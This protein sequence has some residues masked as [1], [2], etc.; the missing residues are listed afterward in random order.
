MQITS[1]KLALSG[2]LKPV[3]RLGL[4]LSDFEQALD[5]ERKK[6]F[7]QQRAASASSSASTSLSSRQPPRSG[8][9]I[10][11]TEE[12]HQA[13]LREDRLLPPRFA[14]RLGAFFSRIQTFA[15]VGD[16]LIGGSQNLIA[17]GVWGALRFCLLG[18]VTFSGYLEKLSALFMRLGTSWS[19][20]ERFAELFPQSEVLQQ[21]LCE[22]LIVVVVLCRK[23]V[24][25]TK[26]NSAS[27]F[28]ATL[29]SSFEDEFSPIQ[30]KMDQWGSIIERQ[31][32]SLAMSLNIKQGDRS[33]DLLSG[34]STRFLTATRQTRAEALSIQIIQ[35]LSAGQDQYQRT[36]RRQKAKGACTWIF[37]HESYKHWSSLSGSSA[38]LI[39]EGKLGSGKTVAMANLVAH[40][41]ANPVRPT[42][43]VFCAFKEPDSQTAINMLRSIAYQIIDNVKPDWTHWRRLKRAWNSIV[44]SLLSPDD[45]IDFLLQLMPQDKQY[46][47][48]IDG[49]ESCPKDESS[50]VFRCLER[51]MHERTVFL[52]YSARTKSRFQELQTRLPPQVLSI[53]LDEA[54][55]HEEIE[56]FIRQEI[57]RRNSNGDLNPEIVSLAVKQLVAGSQGMY[58]WVSLQLDSI[59]PRDSATV[60]TNERVFD[61]LMS[62]PQNLPEAFERA[63]ESITDSSYGVRILKLVT[64]AETPLTV[65]ELRVALTITPGLPVWNAERVPLDGRRLLT[66]CGGDLIEVDEE[67]DRVRVIHYSVVRHLQTQTTNPETQA[68]HCSHEQSQNYMGS[69]CVTY[70]NLPLFDSRL[71]ITSNIEGNDVVEKIKSSVQDD[72]TRLV[73]LIKYIKSPKQ[74][75]EDPRE[76]DLGRLVLEAQALRTSWASAVVAV[77]CFQD[78]AVKHWLTHTQTL[79]DGGEGLEGCWNLWRRLI[80][81]EVQRIASPFPDPRDSKFEAMSWAAVHRHGALF[82]FLLTDLSVPERPELSYGE[83]MT[84]FR[85]L[86]GNPTTCIH[87]KWLGNILAQL[88]HSIVVYREHNLRISDYQ[89][90]ALIFKELHS[91]GADPTIVHHITRQSPMEIILKCLVAAQEDSFYMKRDMDHDRIEVSELLEMQKEAISLFQMPSVGASLSED[92][93]PAMFVR[94]IEQDMLL[95]AEKFVDWGANCRVDAQQDSPLGAAVCH[96]HRDLVCRMVERSGRSAVDHNNSWYR[97]KP[98]LELALDRQDQDM[99]TVLCKI[100]GILSGKTSTGTTFLDMTVKMM[101]LGWPFLLLDQIPPD[102]SVSA[103][104]SPADCMEALKIAV[105]SNRTRLTLKLMSLC[106]SI[107]KTTLAMLSDVA[108][109][110][111]NAILRVWIADYDDFRLRRGYPTPELIT[112]QLAR[113]TALLLAVRQLRIDANQSPQFKHVPKCFGKIVSRR[114]HYPLLKPE[115]KHLPWRWQIEAYLIIMSLVRDAPPEYLNIQDEEGN[116]ALHH[117]SCYI[118]DEKTLREARDESFIALAPLIKLMFAR[119]ARSDIPNSQQKYATWNLIYWFSADFEAVSGRAQK[120]IGTWKD[121]D[122]VDSSLLSKLPLDI[123]DEEG[124]TLLHHMVRSRRHQGRVQEVLGAGANANIRN[125]AG[126]TPLSLAI[127]NTSSDQRAIVALLDAGADPHATLSGNPGQTLL[128]LAIAVRDYHKVHGELFSDAQ[129]NLDV[130]EQYEVVAGMHE[131]QKSTRIS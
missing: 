114:F 41:N 32:A 80:Y 29:G 85:H 123:Q 69:V 21:Y 113:D 127:R 36:W 48:V 115:E 108:T 26:K 109:A 59:F 54:A 82:L 78:Y 99:V 52:C 30:I 130:L 20:H 18:V 56:A 129:S 28:F 102:Q 9:V 94:L 7:Q 37:G 10:R 125:A 89:T 23:V 117:L 107:P 70:L 16:A 103:I 72:T 64:A 128:Q 31:T 84:L 119:G 90:I 43:Y 34:L 120:P 73:R 5:P 100:S 22:Y 105:E 19:L 25:F 124:N 49:L 1:K 33:L 97:G 122:L 42:A 86:Q 12:I 65:D 96:G 6:Q 58:L 71:A 77:T 81:G 91:R 17:S 15:A 88:V 131:S 106:S 40:M 104:F 126:E 75:A 112:P 98:A 13:G 55:H 45:V 66:L 2:Q 35:R 27:K 118:K 61:L 51:L 11:L 76:L 79:E 92:W 87:D 111:E 50:D 121:F 93:V 116:T 60:V 24:L 63:L 44:P 38:T 101:G 4:A 8:D 62:L 46:N 53:S 3:I 47:I 95:I 68:Y 74:T 57:T 83:L 67:D 14:T 39:L 110:R